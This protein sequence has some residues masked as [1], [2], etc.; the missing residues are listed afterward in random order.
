MLPVGGVYTLN[1]IVAFKVMQQVKPRR[2]TI[3]MHYGTIVYGDLLPL[4]YFTDEC[5][6][7]KV[8]ITKSKGGWLKIDTKAPPPKEADVTIMDYNGTPIELKVRKEKE[9]EKEK[10]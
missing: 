1:G 6:E 9:K 7:E 8:P 10:E 3:P 5:K 2:T 4:S